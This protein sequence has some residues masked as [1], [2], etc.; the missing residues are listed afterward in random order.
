M[1]G[2]LREEFIFAGL[3]GISLA[4]F[5]GRYLGSGQYSFWLPEGE[6]DADARVDYTLT[7]EVGHAPQP[8]ALAVWSL[9]GAV[10]VAFM[11]RS[12]TRSRCV[13]G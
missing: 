10:G 12:R 5:T 1:L 7:F 9:L 6:D 13:L 2:D 11:Y 4:G 8:A 3:G